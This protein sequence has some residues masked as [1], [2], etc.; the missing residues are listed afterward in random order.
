VVLQVQ[1]AVTALQVVLRGAPV[2]EAAY[3]HPE[4]LDP[5]EALVHPVVLP[6]EEGGKPYQPNIIYY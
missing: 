5:Q 6:V 3:G 1:E 4:A 2:V